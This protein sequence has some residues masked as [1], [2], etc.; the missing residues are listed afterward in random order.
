MDI[1]DISTAYEAGSLSTFQVLEQLEKKSNHE[2]SEGQKG[3]WAL[4]KM[5]PSMYAYNVPTCFFCGA[6]SLEHLKVAYTHVLKLY[7]SLTSV[8]RQHDTQP[9]VRY[10]D[11]K[12]FK[13]E[14][15]DISLL[16]TNK[17]EEYLRHIVQIPFD[18]SNGPLIKLI[19][20]ARNET[21]FLL[22]VAHHILLDGSSTLILADALFSAY[23]ALMND[24]PLPK[25]G[26]NTTYLDF[27]AWEKSILESKLINSEQEYWKKQLT[28]ATLLDGMPTKDNLTQDSLPQE[29]SHMGDVF[30]CRLPDILESAISD[31]SKKNGISVGVILFGIFRL[32]LSRYTGQ[33][34]IVVGMPV[35]NRPQEKFDSVIGHFV[36][37]MPIR[38][39]LSLDGTFSSYAARL[40]QIIFD[41]LDNANYPF[42][43]LVRD[44]ES[45]ERKN[46]SPV[47]EISYNYQN[48]SF[49]EGFKTLKEKVKDHLDIELFEGLYQTGEY[50]LTLDVLPGDGHLL[51]FKYHPNRYTQSTIEAMSGHYITLL[52][53]VLSKPREVMSELNLLN[54]SEE[55]EL[56]ESNQGLS[57]S[58][59]NEKTCY[60]LFRDRVAV[61][62]DAEAVVCGEV[63]LTYQILDTQ[64]SHV[65]AHLQMREVK[66]KDIIGICVSRSVDM[67]VG[68]LATMKIGAVYVPLDP[69]YPLEHLSYMIDNSDCQLIITQSFLADKLSVLTQQDRELFLIDSQG[70][71]PVNELLDTQSSITTSG[72]LAYIIY[73]SGSMGR[74]KGVMISH[75]ALTNFLLSMKGIFNLNEQD[76]LLAVT[77]YCFDIAALELYLPVISGGRCVICESD[78]VR[79]ASRL[80][81]EIS[82]VRPTIMQATPI[83]WNMLFRVGWE[84]DEAVRILC[85]GE[86][87]TD[88]L[89]ESF[90][91]TGSD[92]WNLYGPT[93]TTI[94][95]SVKQI[96]YDDDRVTIGKPI[97][98]TQIYILNEYYKLKPNGT[99]GNL[100][101]SGAGL[102][103]GYYKDKKLTQEKFVRHPYKENQKIYDT[104][105][106][107]RRLP[108]GEIELIGRSDY[109]VKVRGYR[110]ELSDIECSLNSYP[111]IGS[112]VALVK[113][114]EHT[115]RISAYFTTRRNSDINL[116]LDDLRTYLSQQ[117]PYYMIPSEFFGLQQ[118]PQTP[119][120]KIDRQALVKIGVK[121]LNRIEGVVNSRLI[122]GKVLDIFKE[123]LSREEIG[124]DEGFFDVGGDS[125]TAIAVI[126]KVNKVF[127]IALKV[128]S[129]FRFS[130]IRSISEYLS[131][132]VA[133][134][135]SID[136]VEHQQSSN[137]K[138]SPV[139]QTTFIETNDE[140]P[141][142]YKDSLA[143]V[144][145]SCQF[146]NANNH[147]AF[148]EKLINGKDCLSFFDPEEL[149]ELGE[150]AKLINN[151][152]FVPLRVSIKDKDKFD[153]GFF[154]ISPRDAEFMD[155]Q[156]RLLLQNAWKAVEDAG[157]N[158]DDIP[159]TSVFMSASNNFYQALL[160][161]F[162]SSLTKTRVMDN[163]DEYVGWILAQGGSI[164]T[165]ISNKLGLTGESIFVSS[166][167]S[168]SLSAIHLAG[169]GL[170]S[171]DVDQAIVGASTIFP[172][173]S[174]G[175]VYQPGLNFSSDGH[176][177]A[178]DA[179]ADG[180]VGGEGVAVVVLKRAIEAVR[181]GDNIY[182]VMRGICVNNDGSDKAGFYAPSVKGQSEVIQK[183]LIKTQV[184]PES[185]GY[186]EAHG[187]GTKIG[188]PIEIAALSETYR[189]HTQKN[190][191]CGIGSVKSNI[192]H[193]DTAAGLAGLL[194]VVLSLHHGEIPRTLN[195]Q[196]ANTDID[197]SQSPFYVVNKNQ[198][199]SNN[200]KV[201][202][203]AALSSFGIGGTNAHAIFEQFLHQTTNDN[204]LNSCLNPP[205]LIVLSAKQD[206]Q[207]KENARALLNYIPEYK[208]RNLP[209]SALA[210]TLQI[211]RQP[212]KHRVAFIIEN[213]AALQRELKNYVD[214][215]STSIECFVGVVKVKDDDILSLFYQ[216]NEI[217]E[218]IATWLEKSELNKIAKLWVKGFTIDWKNFYCDVT[219]RRVSLPTYNFAQKRFWIDSSVDS[220]G[221]RSPD[222]Q[223]NSQPHRIESRSMESESREFTDV[224]TPQFMMDSKETH[225]ANESYSDTNQVL[226]P[227]QVIVY[228]KASI[229][230]E[231]AVVLRLSTNEIE[232]NEIFSDYGL[233]SIAGV[234]LVQTINQRLKIEM[235]NT[236]Q[237]DFPTVNNLSQH[238]MQQYGDSI[239]LQLNNSNAI[240]AALDSKAP[241]EPI[242]SL[243]AQSTDDF[244]ICQP[245]G[246]VEQYKTAVTSQKV[247]SKG[248]EAIAVIGMS[249]RFPKS[250]DV[251]EF[252]QHLA[253]GDDLVEEVSRWN[254]SAINGTCKHGG[255]IRDITTFDPLFF[256]ISGIEAEYMEPQQRIFLEE[257][258]KALE[259]AGYAGK[260]ID[261][262]HCGVY[263]G[264]A[265]GDYLDL[266]C[267]DGYPAQAFWGNMNSLVPTRISYFLDLHGPAIAV[268]TACSS[269]LVAVNMACQALWNGEIDMSIAGGI[270]IQCSPR[271][272]IAGSDI[273][274]LSPTGRCSAFDD[275]ADGFV[276]AEGAGVVILKRLSDAQADGDNIY[277][278]I[279]GI[280]VN[281]DGTTNG[282]TAPS[283][284]SQQ[285]LLQ[286][287]YDGFQIDCENIQMIDAHGTGTKL[288]DPIEFRALTNAFRHYTDKQSFCALGSS[289]S[290]TG[291]TQMAAGITSLIKVLL[292][293]KYKKIPPTLHFK[294]INTNI[295]LE[296][297][298]FYINTELKDWQVKPGQKRRAAISSFGVS[299]T[300]VHAVIEEAPTVE[301]STRRTKQR[302]IVLSAETNAKLQ[303]QAEQLVKF[304]QEHTNADIANV[305]YTLLLGRKH[306]SKR[307]ALFAG[308]VRDLYVALESWL[309]Q[310]VVRDVDIEDQNCAAVAQAFTQGKDVDANCL[311]TDGRYRRISLPTYPLEREHYWLGEDSPFLIARKNI[312]VNQPTT[313][314]ET[315]GL[316]K[317]ETE[318]EP[319]PVQLCSLEGDESHY[320][321]TFSGA[322]F[323]LRDHKV[324]G[325]LILPGPIYLE[326]AN[327]AY[328]KIKSQKSSNELAIRLRNIVLMRPL[329]VND[330]PVNTHITFTGGDTN[331][332]EIY[333][334]NPVTSKDEPLTHCRG[335]IQKIIRPKTLSIALNAMLE[336][337]QKKALSSKQFYTKFGALGISY[338]PAFQG[339]QSIYTK[340]GSVLAQINLP[341]L[342]SATLPHYEIHPILVD[343]ALQCLKYLSVGDN[344]DG[345]A[346]LLFAIQEVQLLSPLSSKMWVWL[347]YADGISGSAGAKKIDL[348]IVTESGDVCLTM[349]GILTRPVASM[350]SN[351]L[352]QNTK[353]YPPTFLVPKWDALTNIQEER[354]P[355]AESSVA[356]MGGSQQVQK[357]WMY[358][359]NSAQVVLL[360]PNSSVGEIVKE[361]STLD[362][363]DHLVWISPPASMEPLSANHIVDGQYLGAIEI[364]R[365]LKALN[366][367]GYGTK[368]LGWTMITQSVLTLN[369]EEIGDPTH[370]G[371][372][373]MV[374]AIA[375]EYPNWQIRIVDLLECNQTSLD[376]ILKLP[377]DP[378]GN[379][380]LY[381]NEQ[382]FS[383]V[384]IK[385]PNLVRGEKSPF[386]TN[387][388]YIIVGGAGGLGVAISEYLAETYQAQVIWLGRRK[389]NE[390][391]DASIKKVAK[392]GPAPVYIQADATSA[393]D[394]KRVHDELSEGFGGINGIIQSAMILDSVGMD[395]MTEKQFHD[396]LASK[397]DVS[398]RIVEEFKEEPL[399]FILFISTINSYLK[400]MGQSN[401]AAACTFKDAFSLRM[402]QELPCPVRV[403][404][405]GYC[406][407]NVEDSKENF[408][409]KE[410]VDFIERKDF[411]NSL[412]ILLSGNFKQATFMNF[413][414]KWNTRGM[415]FSDDELFVP[416]V[417]VHSY[418]SEMKKAAAVFSYKDDSSLTYTKAV[419]E[420]N[421]LLIDA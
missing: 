329:A 406:F 88:Q 115:D 299:G 323:F 35:T 193:V 284:N 386:E 352:A 90:K 239:R 75:Q 138:K 291:H 176:C 147:F 133:S 370:S 349:R 390:A 218:I 185:I 360:R 66:A 220:V 301:G 265:A 310:G 303:Q 120:G 17:V 399:D 411:F 307:L 131:S 55:H 314:S 111:L 321:V 417:E 256:S 177:K 246:N 408:D 204:R 222:T 311:F 272:Y 33:S 68:L 392:C 76:C 262:Q 229:V 3:L 280:D 30:S 367:L 234:E 199:I 175:Y 56:F 339:F 201:P 403:A 327:V 169:Q 40:Q 208:R 101:I 324:Q 83:T 300:N 278:V 209:L 103:E 214:S 231:L 290:N 203:R 73:T 412:E 305:S 159:N 125:F 365:I 383:Q 341:N 269:S 151:P 210:Y 343:N 34:D 127:S 182:A 24:E 172:A 139:L 100:F 23:H 381:R 191:F 378:L 259:D 358:Y 2:L 167:C 304:C 61:T 168:S 353:K 302:L 104:G 258:W 328:S 107:G 297:S 37:M 295:D 114:D 221:M 344:D 337:H 4:A 46:R 45:I 338:G 248:K 65:A 418:I 165:M 405:M 13:V 407:N 62:P 77:T 306:F 348:D 142:Y 393:E 322:E 308:N 38:C 351:A 141:K 213:F 289:K 183:T 276:P 192:G 21:N 236:V 108:N 43:S 254:M 135:D 330:A 188:D 260:A 325:N 197:F 347:R 237:Y 47:F 285:R 50:D 225:A 253:N 250:D 36:N 160:P 252:W 394:L 279:R 97:A 268:D 377:P 340:P 154:N 316:S 264:C 230:Q 200:S 129:L 113:K 178:F 156:S 216:S 196:S 198:L 14:C 32:L 420:Q 52:N 397:V 404:N 130:T 98:N 157:Y 144:G 162:A 11:E 106:L 286:N 206:E 128:T 357:E 331:Q 26:S 87:L 173:K 181:D 359:Y 366:Q 72:S 132:L 375:K 251:T 389:Q 95:S 249:G 39:E 245:A 124:V 186:I 51:N 398:V 267:P 228:I 54:A 86:K 270:Y 380:T 171:K 53:E 174:Y 215:T 134:E 361:L 1:K 105:D 294:N 63:T 136:L 91:S 332:F 92:L 126:E 242:T 123:I 80:S 78:I 27:V 166:N 118:L 288:G 354:W 79:D 346:Q 163:T 70:K 416:T 179:K 89:R 247:S 81:E 401:Y 164:P 16:K 318:P 364:F 335:E 74:P 137:V 155:P 117:L 342:V 194:K 400:A 261:G 374:G 274:M 184:D 152:N 356:I 372:T 180:M 149:H 273:G 146:P 419:E 350:N 82:R 189:L 287:V 190:Q 235:E 85:G 391:I 319:L 334:E 48:F 60:E 205:Y 395:K 336:S 67:L 296:N 69:E 143:I 345:Q 368:N 277:G 387:S 243:D 71:Q 5:E 148:W 6:I 28:G 145:I 388:V 369:E 207:L 240:V 44:S 402:E 57:E 263:V 415:L 409:E 421:A 298:P 19:V 161:G 22:L 373:G 379:T 64:V 116:N 217:D 140:F 382:W 266:N 195:Y 122:E 292:A 93:E 293:L 109:Q 219:V 102:A 99:I 226:T 96:T 238:I 158:V 84:N 396:V 376:A 25:L 10:T 309:N 8:I 283:A 202:Y 410:M 232:D 312:D 9:F 15:Q 233:E 275:G 112:S 317:S 94:W 170:L 187:T 413:S 371:V 153:P 257:A 227:I 29:I 12:N 212:M 385:A 42:S 41:A 223:S 31:Y 363:I 211:G 355:N 315:I 313:Q 244:K 18:L 241:I 224:K 20:L 58:Y 255:F 281:Q 59:Q 326:L 414:P 362:S 320:Q 110:V 150:K 333:S 282:I 49:S 121:K 384:L 119:N 271:L 7:P